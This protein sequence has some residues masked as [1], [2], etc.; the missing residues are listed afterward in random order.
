MTI[1]NKNIIETCRKASRAMANKDTPLILNEWYVAAF[2]Q[3]IGRHLLARKI[4]NK[5]VVMYRTLEGLAVALEDRCAH[6][7]F[8]LSKSHLDGNDIIC[9]YH[10]FKYNQAGDL[11][12][13]PSQKQCPHG[14]GIQHYKLVEKGPLLWIWLGDQSLAD[15]SKIP[16]LAWL[17]HPEWACT[18]GYFFHPGNYVSMHENLMDLTHLTF[19]HAQTIGTPD[20]ASAPYKTELKEGHY[21]LIREVVPTT[22]SKVW[23]ETTGLANTHTA[24]RIA[25]SEFLSPALHQVSVAFYDA[26]LDQ[27]QRTTYKIHTAHIL[28]PETQNTMHYFIVHGRDFAL[29]DQAIED[30][31]HEQLFAAFQEDVEGLGALEAVLDDQDQHHFEIS[32]ASD[33]PAVATRIYLKKRAEQEQYSTS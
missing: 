28:T 32:V 4:L 15:E 10:G 2:S 17:D 23:G 25:T 19:L 14:I 8:P 1:P 22:L 30:F 21:K 27:K 31:M 3:D 13:I 24:A 29:E 33:S 6:R 7:S 12:N 9:G 20:Y 26:A 16:S 11:I 5:R 18:S